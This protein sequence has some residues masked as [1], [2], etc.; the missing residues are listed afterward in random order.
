MTVFKLERERPAFDT[1]AGRCFYVKERYLRLHE[2]GNG[3]DIP[4]V[5]LRRTTPN[6]TPGIGGGPRHLTYNS[7]NKAENDVL[8]MSDAEGGTYELITFGLE[9]TTTGEALDVRRGS[10]LAAAFIARD[11]FIVLD[12]FHNIYFDNNKN[13]YLE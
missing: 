10:G 11:R 13:L 12:N 4:L 6:I 9:N 8:I 3:R 7:L 2:F 1:Q 5:S